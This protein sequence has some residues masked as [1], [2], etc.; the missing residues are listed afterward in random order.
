MRRI[1]LLLVAAG[2]LA[3]CGRE[4]TAPSAPT[5]E[6]IAANGVPLAGPGAGMFGR[7]GGAPLVR[8]LRRLPGNLALTATQKASIQGYVQ[9]FQQATVT[10][11][12]ALQGLMKQARAAHRQGATGDQL[13]TI[14]QQGA[15][16]RQSIQTAGAQ[17]KEQITGVL[18]AGQKA[19][20]TSNAPQPC[21]R[22][23]ATPLTDAQKTQIKS[24][25][26][27]FRG[28]NTADLEAVKQAMQK[29]HAARKSGAG[30]DQVQAIFVTVKPNMD[31]LRTARQ[32]LAQDI[33]GVLTADQKA[34]G[35][36][37]GRHMGPGAGMRLGVFGGGLR[38]S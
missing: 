20:L 9:Q 4:L 5:P 30:K 19:W 29:A 10:D 1:L 22:S 38:Q 2:A 27:A 24:L 11:R 17:L 33:Q 18:T 26:T 32:K 31:R 3:A 13:K 7:F 12:Q 14:L 23:K 15:P 34:T 6:G 8:L 21:D 37:T 25:T 35:C 16:N 36:F 28:A